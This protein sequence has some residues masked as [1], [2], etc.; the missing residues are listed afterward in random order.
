MIYFAIIKQSNKGG[1]IS[2][3]GLNFDDLGLTPDEKGLEPEKKADKIDS[4]SHKRAVRELLKTLK[5]G[6][7]AD[8]MSAAWQLSRVKGDPLIIRGL[9]NAV[10]HQR[11]EDV[12]HEIISALG[13]L[14]D[15]SS[16]MALVSV[17]ANNR[18][19]Y[20]RRKT[21]W[22]LSNM[23]KSD[24]ALGA[25]EAAML[26]DA[27]DVVRVEAAWGLGNLGNPKAIGSL[28]DVLVADQSRQVRKMA[29]WSLG[30]VGNK[31]VVE[32]LERT[33]SSDPDPEVRR[34]AAWV[35]GKKKLSESKIALSKSLRLEHEKE[36]IRMII[37]AL[38]KM[39]DENISKDMKV[40]FEEDHFGLEAQKEAAYVLGRTKNKKG[41]P[42]IVDQLPKMKKS[43]KEVM[44]W[45]L[46]KIGDEDSVRVLRRLYRKEKN[47]EIKDEM[48]WVINEIK[49]SN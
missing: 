37:W 35:L 7:K 49:A 24:K 29:V 38:S 48:T 42:I 22:A 36:V 26:S 16:I 28:V 9:V 27:E 10:G 3:F 39:E 1:L 34:E 47:K 31:E 23:K 46:G 40:V 41:A 44:L 25:L 8:R 33:L 19:P 6:K 5:T 2:D 15:E 43:V 14:A 17:L 45:A 12:L 13:H 11:D 18:K 32:F 30:E 4:L 21:A 20:L